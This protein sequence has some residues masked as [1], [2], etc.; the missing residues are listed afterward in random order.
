M[1]G[2]ITMVRDGPLLVIHQWFLFLIILIASARDIAK[3]EIPNL[4]VAAVFT[5]GLTVQL[6]GW[7]EVSWMECLGGL[8]LG[9]AL[10][11]PVF[12]AG[13]MG[14]GDV[15][16]I[17]ACGLV[18]GWRAELSFVLYTAV[19]GGFIALIAR[20]AGMADYPYAPA[21]AV[22]L[23]THLVLGLQSQGTV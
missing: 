1:Q 19:S 3:R 2:S 7:S 18:L 4:L 11:I 15:K 22:G 23:F 12:A 6:A 9:L 5:L 20:R 8:L 13:G 16:L 17:A 14:G 10:G 21:I